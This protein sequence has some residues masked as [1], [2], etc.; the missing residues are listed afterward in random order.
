MWAKNAV[1]GHQ[2]LNGFAVY[3]IRVKFFFERDR[4]LARWPA[5]PPNNPLMKRTPR[6]FGS[7]TVYFSCIS[8]A[9][10]ATDKDAVRLAADQVRGRKSMLRAVRSHSKEKEGR[11]VNP[12]PS[13]LD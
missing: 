4:G 5:R 1:I 7:S 13:R 8:E 6:H 12:V 11:D 2:I 3:I 9:A 10:I